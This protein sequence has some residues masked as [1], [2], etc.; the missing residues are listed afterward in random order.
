MTVMLI[1]SII[2]NC[3]FGA[4]EPS[5]GTVTHKCGGVF[6]F[7]LAKGKIP[8]GET[9]LHSGGEE[10]KI[11]VPGGAAHAVTGGAG[12]GQAV[13]R[14]QHGAVLASAPR[15]KGYKRTHGLIKRHRAP[16]NNQPAE[17]RLPNP[18]KVQT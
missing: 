10:A 14:H 8:R 1:M 17:L 7:P 4:R 9:Q 5:G 3:R 6:S 2:S 12:R 18:N 13:R 16:I 15:D 11:A